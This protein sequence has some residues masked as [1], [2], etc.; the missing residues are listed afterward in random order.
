MK[1]RD[2]QKI[3]LTEIDKVDVESSG[4]VSVR[5]KDGWSLFINANELDGFVP[6]VGD[7]MLVSYHGFNTIAGIIIEG[8]VIRNKTTAQCEAEHEQWRKNYRLE[9]LERYIKDGDALKAEAYALPKPI[10]LRFKRFDHENGIDFW[11]DDASYE[12]HAMKGAAALLRKVKELGLVSN[13]DDIDQ[14][15]AEEIEAGTKWIEEWHTL[16]QKEGGYQH[17]KQMEIVPDFGEGHSGNTYGA[18]VSYALGI[19]KGTVI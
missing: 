15:T 3:E 4:G 18:A 16:G 5:Q 13:I 19:L 6:Q 9:K 7:W 11:I 14:N 1:N 8:R 12:M 2:G 10:A 17:E